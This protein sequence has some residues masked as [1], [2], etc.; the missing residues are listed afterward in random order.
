MRERVKRCYECKSEKSGLIFLVKSTTFYPVYICNEC[1]TK[2]YPWLKHGQT[3]SQKAWLDLSLMKQYTYKGEKEPIEYDETGKKESRK[4]KYSSKK[5]S[6]TNEPH[7]FE[8]VKPRHFGM[9]GADNQLISIKKVYE[10]D[11]E[12]SRTKN[13]MRDQ[14]FIY[15]K[16]TDCGKEDFKFFPVD[17]AL[18]IIKEL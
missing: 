15:Y 7:R 5:C 10:K 18:K 3:I 6:K 1:K 8:I 2:C 12:S 4:R 14:V 17:K 11:I 13:W 9:L 16:C